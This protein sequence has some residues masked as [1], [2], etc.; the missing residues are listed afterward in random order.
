MHQPRCRLEID[1]KGSRL[2]VRRQPDESRVDDGDV[3]APWSQLDAQALHQV[4]EGRLGG[5]VGGGVGQ[6]AER[7]QAAGGD[8]V[9][10]AA[11]QH[12][13]QDRLNAGRRAADIEGER[14]FDLGGGKAVDIGPLATAGVGDQPIDRPQRSLDLADRIE[15]VRPLGD[16]AGKR[17]GPAA[18]RLDVVNHVVEQR[19]AAGQ[20]GGRHRRSRRA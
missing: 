18:R 11:G 12:A 1:L 2:L 8:E 16:V 3:D 10:G 4:G 13:G 9:T 19:L 17:H 14:A 5:A 15:H 7:G 6:A 20:D